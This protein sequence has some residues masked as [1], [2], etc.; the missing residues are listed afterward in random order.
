[1]YQQIQGDI[2]MVQGRCIIVQ[3]VNCQKDIALL[4][5]IE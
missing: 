4:Q 3:Q 5:I 1:M 2:T